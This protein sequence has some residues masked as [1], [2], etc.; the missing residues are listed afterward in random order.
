MVEALTEL[1]KGV[2]ALIDGPLVEDELIEEVTALLARAVVEGVIS[3]QDS[4][5][6]MITLANQLIASGKIFA[7]QPV[8]LGEV[9]QRAGVTSVPNPTTPFDN[10]T[11]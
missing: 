6:W 5:D 10:F 3:S 9:F 1:K 8:S 7:N 2:Q 11:S 4:V